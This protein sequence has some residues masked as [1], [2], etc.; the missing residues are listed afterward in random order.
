MIKFRKR[1]RKPADYDASNVK[2]RP[3]IWQESLDAKRR[4]K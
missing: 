1:L 2:N 4:G 3:I